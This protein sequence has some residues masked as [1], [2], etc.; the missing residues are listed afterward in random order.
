MGTDTAPEPEIRKWFVVRCERCGHQWDEED[1]KA[2]VCACLDKYGHR[3]VKLISASAGTPG[4]WI[5][6]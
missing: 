5:V 4:D 1:P 6:L 3:T 2:E